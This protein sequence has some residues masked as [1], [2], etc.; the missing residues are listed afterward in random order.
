MGDQGLFAGIKILE[1]GGGAAGPLGTRY[2]ADHG[3]TVIRIES[4]KRPDFIRLLRMTPD[5]PG[6]LDASPMFAM[7]NANKYGIALNLSHI[8]GPEIARRLVAWADVVAENFAP[9][10]MAKWGLDYASLSKVK[11][12]LIMISTCLNGQTGPESNYPGFGGQGAALAGFNHMTGWAELEPLGPYGTITDSLSPRCLALLVG[13][14][15]LHRQR[16]GR[17]QYIDLSQVEG[18]V[19][20]LTE[21]M[22]TYGATGDALGRIGNRS[23]HAAPHGAFRCA[24]QGG[25]DDRWVVLA[26]HNDEDWQRFGTAIGSPPWTTDPRFATTAGR[27]AHV[28]E[29]Q[30]FVTAW[31]RA[32][33]AEEVVAQLQGAG[34][35]AGI[36]ENFEDLIQDPQ[37]AHRRHFRELHHPVVGAH[38]VEANAIR[39]SHDSEQIRMPA[40]CLGQ[41]NEY[42]YREMLEM[43]AEEYAA[44]NADGVF[45]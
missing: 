45:M 36:V 33:A 1:F 28:D 43:S 17:G 10:A 11:P 22:L 4:R 13:S 31:T 14:A 5:T 41:H 15:L 7:L 38:L 42:V 34:V 12:D 20:C 26:V 3:A 27:L 35:D 40:P 39:F 19:V 6:G 37:L 16:T 8:K 21:M 2:F 44:L 29:L 32:H 23:R 24:P 25:D 9:K 30:T 18:G